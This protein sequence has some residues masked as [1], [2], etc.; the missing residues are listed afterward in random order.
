MHIALVRHGKPLGAHNPVVNA[1][2]FARWARAYERS[3]LGADSAPPLT[4]TTRFHG[5]VAIVSSRPRSLH[6]ARLCLGR[7]PDLCLTDLREMEIP[8]YRMPLRIPAY[9]WLVLNRALWMLGCRGR[10]ES[11]DAARARA[12]RVSVELHR[13]AM[14]HGQVVVFGHGLMNRQ[15]AASLVAL[16]WDGRPRRTDYWDVIDLR[17]RAP[18]TAT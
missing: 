8:R 4:L 13:L 12:R 6:S 2:G 16:G 18:G 17:M 7:E 11:F 9:G 10:V 15:V 14:T 5:Y 3:A 1:S